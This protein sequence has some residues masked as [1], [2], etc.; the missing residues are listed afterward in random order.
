MPLVD[1][2]RARFCS[3]ATREIH[4]ELPEELGREYGANTVARLL[5]SMYGAKDA[6]ANWE[7]EVGRVMKELG[8][9]RGTSNPCLYSR[10][11]GADPYASARG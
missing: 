8:F 7:K 11:H 3:S 4:V 9:V 1:I 10:P 2:R 5:M 6:G